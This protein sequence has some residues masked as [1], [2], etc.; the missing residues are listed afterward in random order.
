MIHTAPTIVPFIKYDKSMCLDSGASDHMT[1]DKSKLT[2]IS[3]VLASVV[4]PDGSIAP[5][6]G[7]GTIQI[8]LFDQKSRR[9]VVIPLMNTLYV[10]GL[11]KTLW[12]VTQFASEGHIII[13]GTT[14]VTIILN[15][16][17][18]NEVQLQIAHLFY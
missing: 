16:Q 12:S 7:I 18:Q 14:N 11:K 4:F 1:G 8:A 15:Y 17:R 6:A 9:R 2:G 10:P 3:P 5:A 13:F